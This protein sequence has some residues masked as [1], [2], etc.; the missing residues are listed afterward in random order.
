MVVEIVMF[1]VLLVGYYD[2]LFLMMMMKVLVVICGEYDDIV[3]LIGI[4]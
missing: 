4:C 2:F 3:L 1:L